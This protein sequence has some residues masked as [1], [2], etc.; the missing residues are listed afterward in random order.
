[1]NEIPESITINISKAQ[2]Q[3]EYARLGIKDKGVIQIGNHEVRIKAGETRQWRL[4]FEFLALNFMAK[5]TD[6]D[7]IGVFDIKTVRKYFA[8]QMG[9]SL[10]LKC[11]DPKVMNGFVKN[12]TDTD[13]TE[14]MTK[15]T[16]NIICVK[17]AEFGEIRAP[18]EG[19][20]EDILHKLKFHQGS[21]DVYNRAT[22][23]K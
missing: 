10:I 16:E 11:R 18:T 8:L 2:L 9:L 22:K 19:E 14:I 17:T 3:A 20:I 6:H 21:E 12:T 4:D 1:M 7:V 13:I 15:V 23:W 5:Y